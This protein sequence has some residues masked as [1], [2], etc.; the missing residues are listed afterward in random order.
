MTHVLETPAKLSPAPL[1]LRALIIN[2][3]ER[4]LESE[5]EL[6]IFCFRMMAQQPREHFHFKYDCQKWCINQCLISTF[7]ES[8]SQ[9]A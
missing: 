9:C 7:P 2:P 5:K 4:A 3:L 1:L 8:T 6:A